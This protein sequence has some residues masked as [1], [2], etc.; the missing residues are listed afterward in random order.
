MR[1]KRGFA[2]IA[3]FASTAGASSHP[4]VNVNNKWSISSG[5]GVHG[6]ERSGVEWKCLS[7]PAL[8]EGGGWKEGEWKMELDDHAFLLFASSSVLSPSRKEGRACPSSCS[9]HHAKHMLS[10]NVGKYCR[11]VV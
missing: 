8:M 4:S 9:S 7:R 2:S 6:K 5:E 11:R 10:K 3:C 1:E